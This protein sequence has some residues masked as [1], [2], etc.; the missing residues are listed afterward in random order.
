MSAEKAP[1]HG[2]SGRD[3]ALS[4]LASSAA[5]NIPGVD[6]VS[7]TVHDADQTLYTAAATDPLAERADALQYELREG[8][9]YSA[10][11]D[12]RFV[13]VNDMPAAAEFPRFAPRA[14]DLGVGAHAA[15]QLVDGRRR[16]GL[17]LYARTAGSFDRATVQFA[18]LFAAQAG[19]ILGYAEQ[20][21]QL[22]NAVQTRTDIGTAVGILMELRRQPPPGLR[23]PDPELPIPEHQGAGPGPTGHRRH[24]GSTGSRAELSPRVPGGGGRDP[25]TRPE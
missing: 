2:S 11:T 4:S 21:E 18:E 23:V 10:V 25:R 13:L 19:A 7:I 24:V 17:N 9:C 3:A 12:E 16:A 20:V 15:I 22:S 8:P 5:D 1:S 14:V 6:F